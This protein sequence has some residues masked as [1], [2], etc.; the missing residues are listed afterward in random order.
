MSLINLISAIGNNKGVAPF[1]VRDCC[2]EIP[3]K[4]GLTYKQNLKDSKQMANN[5]TRERL[6]DEYGTSAVWIGGPIIMDAFSNWAIKKYG[7]NAGVNMNLFKEAKFQGIKYNIEKFKEKAPE[8]VKD[9]QNALKNKSKF[10][11]LQAGK[12]LLSTLIPI[13][14]MGFILPKLNFKLTEKLNKR[15]KNKNAVNDNKTINQS[16]PSFKGVISTMAN[17]S[18]VNKMAVTDGGLTIGRVWTGRNT[19]EQ[20]ELGFKN[21]MMMFLNFVFPIYLAK[22]LDKTS[23]KLFNLNVNLDPKL[24][25][26]EEFLADIKNNTIKT[27][28]NMDEVIEFLDKNPNSKFSK[29]C[30]E[31]CGVKYLKNRIRDPRE[32]VNIEKIYALKEEIEKFGKE[33]RKSNDINKYAKK[34]LKVKSLNIAANI[35][36]SSF[37]L[38]VALPE[39]IFFLRKKITGSDA[40][41]GL[42]KVS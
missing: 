31:Y 10:Q 34:A 19:F 24:M 29:L 42:M 23:M 15:Q 37:L 41:P 7:Y 12:F 13:T 17:M 11:R 38:A 22:C 16:S 32:F 9:L 5:A 6:I 8:A 2:I 35:G 28:R 39:L 20:M 25:N 1:I 26:N 30:E 40:E 33:A 3:T 18:N 4:V 21:V 14:L 27:P 36:I